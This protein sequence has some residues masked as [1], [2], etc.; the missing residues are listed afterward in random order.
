[1][2]GIPGPWRSSGQPAPASEIV[3]VYDIMGARIDTHAASH[4]ALGQPGMPVYLE[5]DSLAAL[6][7]QLS[8]LPPARAT[9]S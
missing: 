8:R 9:G 2:P 4:P 3:K 5:A 1:M 6:Q 7:V